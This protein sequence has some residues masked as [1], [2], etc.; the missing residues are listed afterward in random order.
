ML[1]NRIPSNLWIEIKKS[2]WKWGNIFS[3]LKS[4]IRI[5]SMKLEVDWK[6]L[7]KKE[8]KETTGKD[9]PKKRWKQMCTQIAQETVQQGKRNWTPW[10]DEVDKP[11]ARVIRKWEKNKNF[12]Y[13]EGHRTTHS[14]VIQSEIITLCQHIWKHLDRETIKAPSRRTTI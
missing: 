8:E 2:Q 10:E 5:C 4:H 13:Q 6:A 9:K 3:Q 1:K 11:L 7:K 12:Q 14:T